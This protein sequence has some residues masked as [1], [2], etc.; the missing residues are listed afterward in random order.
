MTRVKI[1]AATLLVFAASGVAVAQTPVDRPTN[2]GAAAM[3]YANAVR[4]LDSLGVRIDNTR[5]V[6]LLGRALNGE[7]VGFESIDEAEGW[8]ADALRPDAIAPADEAAETAWVKEKLTTEP[9][10]V[11]LPGG[12]VFQCIIEGPGQQ[13]LVTD[14]LN[15]MYVGRLSNGSIFDQTNEPFAMPVDRVVPGLRIA[16]QQMRRGGTYRVYIP[17]TEAYGTRAIMDVIPANS[18]LDFEITILP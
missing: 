2:E 17:P 8:L 15:V 6:E 3:I 9:N 5:F 7:N 13:P 4:R 1:A 18:A 16:L 12:T 10:T 11:E 14:V